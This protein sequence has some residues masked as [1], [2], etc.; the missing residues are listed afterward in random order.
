MKETAKSVCVH[1]WLIDNSIVGRCKKCGTVKDFGKLQAST[2][3]VRH[4]NSKPRTWKRGR[5]PKPKEKDGRS[6]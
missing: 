5:H 1:Q 4:D 3:K 2:F 6:S